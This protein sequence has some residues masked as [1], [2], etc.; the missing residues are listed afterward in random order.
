M[1]FVFFA[2][3]QP[4]IEPDIELD[5]SRSAKEP[6]QDEPAAKCVLMTFFFGGGVLCKLDIELDIELDIQVC[7]SVFSG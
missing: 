2:P 3:R 6:F 7:K 5:T 4:D 1:T